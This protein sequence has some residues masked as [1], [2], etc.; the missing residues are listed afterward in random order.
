M[1]RES[2]VA[3]HWAVLMAAAL[4]LLMAGAGVAYLLMRPHRQPDAAAPAPSAAAPPQAN[5]PTAGAAPAGASLPDVIVTLGEEA[6]QRA[7]IVTGPVQNRSIDAALTLPGIVEPNA[8]RQVAV[9]PA[10][11]GRV[12]RV[13]A[14]LGQPVRRGQALA[15][16]FSPELAE[17]QRAYVSARAELDA[18]E[19]ELERTS[20]LV[21]IGAASRQELER[22]EA[23]H[24]A[25]A[26]AVQT[27]RSRLLLQGMSEAAL[28]R[29]ASGSQVAAAAN[30]AAPIDGFVTERIANPGLNVDPSNKLFTVVD[31]STV[32][33]VGDV[34]ERDFVR[35]R[36]GSA[37]TVR[38]AA[39]PDLAL[40]GTVSYIDPQVDPDTRTARARIEVPNPKRQLRLG[41]YAEVEVH[42]EGMPA[43]PVVPKSAVQDVGDR[44]VVYVADRGRPGTFTEREV[45][46][47][48]RSG[49]DVEV[50]SGLGAGDLVVVRNSFY[51]RAERERLGL[52]PA[53]AS[54]P[55][56]GEAAKAAQKQA[57]RVLVT[58][59]GFEPPRIE[60]ARG[61]PVSLTF[62]RTSDRTCATEVA[63][64]SLNLERPLPLN[65]PVTIE[66][67]AQRD[68]S[69]EFACGMNMLKGTVVVK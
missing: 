52:R 69:I 37:A 46:L 27:G 62:V 14:E 24:T 10:I 26:T 66:L 44:H 32:W 41:M 47:G 36:A 4:G 22:V 61:T 63:F 33:V 29:L 45:R 20:K 31:L 13:L 54:P 28:D 40:K 11:S 16:V 42:G 49:D 23:E 17:A 53:I 59:R 60:V 1:T 39:Y 48:R 2:R 38:L 19:R 68:G 43:R 67:P 18:H 21:E 35:V 5:P 58:D 57:R 25:A 15:E 6:A 55:P 65:Q 50:T 51:L 9:T 30:V 64:S 7:G 8:Y 3:V 34:Y 56:S 12:T